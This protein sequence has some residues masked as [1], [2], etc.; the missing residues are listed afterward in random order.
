MPFEKP[1][2]A[3][4]DDRQKKS[5]VTASLP[6]SKDFTSAKVEHFCRDYN[7]RWN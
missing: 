2:T 4:S 5:E 7:T 3:E 6:A 1:M